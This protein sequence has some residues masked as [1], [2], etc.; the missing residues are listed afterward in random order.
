MK[1]EGE[2]TMENK[3]SIIIDTIDGSETEEVDLDS[4]PL[5][6]LAKLVELMPDL[7]GYYT[8]RMI[9]EQKKN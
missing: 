8:Q 2:T 6:N 5:E 7:A 3:I 9:E 4:L 1:N